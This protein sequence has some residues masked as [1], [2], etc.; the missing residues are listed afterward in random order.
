LA[1]FALGNLKEIF[2]H[3]LCCEWVQAVLYFLNKDESAV[4]STFDL[5]YHFYNRRLACSKMELRVVIDL[6]KSHQYTL[7]TVGF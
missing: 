1:L 6:S 5:S 7:G 3:F 4:V 2:N